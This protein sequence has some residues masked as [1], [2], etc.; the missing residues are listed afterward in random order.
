MVDKQIIDI[1]KGYIIKVAKL[2]Q[3]E[4]AFIF[5]SQVNG[6]SYEDSDIDIAVI[7]SGEVDFFKVQ[8]DLFKL[9]WKYNTKI[10]PHLF[11]EE[12]IENKHPRLSNIL[13]N[14]YKINLN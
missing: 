3:L 10:E 6:S 4:D 14:G 5:G 1:A 13:K 12:D 8:A 2:Y 7:I 11:F 9:T